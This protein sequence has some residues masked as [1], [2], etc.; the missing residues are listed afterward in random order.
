MLSLFYLKAIFCV[1][2]QKIFLTKNKLLLNPV[3]E[4]VRIVY[5]YV[6]KRYV[7]VTVSKN[8]IRKINECLKNILKASSF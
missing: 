1:C 8:L 4:T 5:N 2:T 3:E 6:E 7:K